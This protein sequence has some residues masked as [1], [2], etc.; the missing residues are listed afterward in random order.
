MILEDLIKVLSDDLN[1]HPVIDMQG[2]DPD[3]VGRGTGP[4]L[5]GLLKEVAGRHD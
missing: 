4:V 1:R 5:K 2:H 3:Q